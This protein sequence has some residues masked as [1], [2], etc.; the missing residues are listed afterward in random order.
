MPEKAAAK[1]EKKT[2]FGSEFERALYEKPA[3][4]KLYK[5]C[6]VGFSC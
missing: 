5:E 1:K 6:Q 4:E 2:K 3:F